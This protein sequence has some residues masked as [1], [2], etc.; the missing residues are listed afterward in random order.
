MSIFNIS[1]HGKPKPIGESPN[2]PTLIL[3]LLNNYYSNPTT[4]SS[5][6]N[7]QPT[8]RERT[9][10]CGLGAKVGCERLSEHSTCSDESHK[11]RFFLFLWASPLP[12]ANQKLIPNFS[13]LSLI[14][15]SNSLSVIAVTRP[16]SY[17]LS[18]HFF[19]SA[20]S[21]LFLSTALSP[22]RR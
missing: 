13:L 7:K 16:V 5:T 12:A 6:A 15:F 17:S 1:F 3:I 18:T 21:G 8:E 11:Y 10:I 4:Y 2:P 14:T 20:T 22:F 9:Y 19:T